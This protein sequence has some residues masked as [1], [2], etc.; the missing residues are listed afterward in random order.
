MTA[1]KGPG[2]ENAKD[3]PVRAAVLGWPASHSLSPRLHGYWLKELAINGTYRA[4]AV[5]P[6]EFTD[7]LHALAREGYKGFNVTLPHK[8]A[9]LTAVDEVDV[10]ARRIGA[11]NTIVVGHDG[12]LLG[13]NTDGYGFIENIK[14]NPAGLNAGAIIAS[15]PAVVLGAGGAARSV[16]AALD[17]AGAA[18][19]RI[20]NRTVEKAR[21]LAHD[22]GG[23]H[24]EKGAAMIVLSWPEREKALINA[25][26]LVNTT[27][28]GMTGRPALEIGLDNLPPDALVTDIVYTPLVT[29]LL[30]AAAERGNPVV[31]GLGML[32]HQARP[33]FN[34]WFGAWP[35]ITL[36]L[37]EYIL[38]AQGA[39]E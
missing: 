10:E 5:R 27:A 26:L 36:G 23:I 22:I 3:Q 17:N 15:G 32:I 24:R 4:I 39:R 38:A 6:E 9:A 30:A 1:K 28:L 16:V 21:V 25:A 2:A 8:E 37:R 33:G 29:P 19:I 18:E 35:E 12:R 31:D 14:A 34:A 11:V 20:V 7:K 13:S